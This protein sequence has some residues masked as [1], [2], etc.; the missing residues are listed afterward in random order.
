MERDQLGFI[1]LRC[2]DCSAKLYVSDDEALK[3]APKAICLNACALT[4]GAYRRMQHGLNEA[5][6][7]YAIKA[8]KSSD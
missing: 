6:V 5:Y 8:I 3:E 2:P 4:V 7:R 1:N